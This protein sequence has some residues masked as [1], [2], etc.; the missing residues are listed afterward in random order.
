VPN[1][2]SRVTALLTVVVV[3]FGGCGTSGSSEP[4]RGPSSLLPTSS[5]ATSRSAVPITSGEPSPQSVGSGDAVCSSAAIDVTL[6]SDRTLYRAGEPVSLTATAT[7]TGGSPC[8]LPTGNC[9]PQI[10]IADSVGR[11]VWDR[12]A[13]V[14]VCTFGAPLALAPETMSVQM[15]VW[16]GTF[17]TGR[18]PESCPGRPVSGGTYKASAEWNGAS[19]TTTIVVET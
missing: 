8:N 7:N 9:L 11:V 10:Q 18:T 3:A 14:V 2:R 19:G 1:E 6:V 16:D 17:C 15:V 12:A 5:P 13:T 4:S